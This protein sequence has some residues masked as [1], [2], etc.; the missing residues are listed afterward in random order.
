MSSKF[1]AVKLLEQYPK[2]K[3]KGK[4]GKLIEMS[5]DLIFID[6]VGKIERITKCV[7]SEHKFKGKIY[8]DLEIL[9]SVLVDGGIKDWESKI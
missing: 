9:S 6:M 1:N 7:I 4:K 3:V 8:N 2:I 5:G